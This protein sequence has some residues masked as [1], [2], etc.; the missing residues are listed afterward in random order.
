MKD[1]WI[2]KAKKLMGT[3]ALIHMP[4]KQL[5]ALT[6]QNQQNFEFPHNVK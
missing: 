4:K 1:R 3:C 5:I 6:V 2:K